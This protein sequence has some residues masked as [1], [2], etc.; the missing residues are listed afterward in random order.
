MVPEDLLSEPTDGGMMDVCTD[1]PD[2]GLR[3]IPSSVSCLIDLG[4]RS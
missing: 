1:V 2:V 4:A 3:V